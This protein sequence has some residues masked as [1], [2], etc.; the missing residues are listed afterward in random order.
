[1]RSWWGGRTSSSIFGLEDRERSGTFCRGGFADR[2][3]TSA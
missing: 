1:M 2:G 3:M